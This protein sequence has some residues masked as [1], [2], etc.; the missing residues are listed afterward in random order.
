MMS[1]NKAESCSVTVIAL[2][3]LS[4]LPAPSSLDTLVLQEHISLFSVQNRI[5]RQLRIMCSTN[6]TA[7]L[8]PN[9]H[10]KA[11]ASVFKLERQTKN[12][13]S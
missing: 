11:M 1:A 4:G 12:N 7:A 2:L 8:K 9:A 6:L 13:Q 10:M 5:V 3:A